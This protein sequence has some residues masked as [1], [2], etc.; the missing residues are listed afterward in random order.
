MKYEEIK[1]NTRILTEYEKEYLINK[2][3][4][5]FN[6]FFKKY[7][8]I[9]AYMVQSLEQSYLNFG[10]NVICT[11]TRTKFR[12]TM[13]LLDYTNDE[14]NDKAEIDLFF[15]HKI[16]NKSTYEIVRKDKIIYFNFLHKN[17]IDFF[18]LQIVFVEAL[19]HFR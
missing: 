4:K 16:S 18:N 8:E 11:L 13:N 1:M 15:N 17:D 14:Y 2:T 10:A 7:N 6:K 3:I 5:F 12:N 19:K 9:N